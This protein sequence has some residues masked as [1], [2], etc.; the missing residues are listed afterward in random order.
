MESQISALNFLYLTSQDVETRVHLIGPEDAC[1]E[2]KWDSPDCRKQ[3]CNVAPCPLERH[4]SVLVFCPTIG[5]LSCKFKSRNPVL[6]NIELV[7][8]E[9]D[10]PIKGI[11]WCHASFIKLVLGHHKIVEY[12]I[13][14]Q[15]ML[16]SGDWVD[17]S[18]SCCW[19]VEMMESTAGG[20]FPSI[21][22][23]KVWKLPTELHL[24]KY[25]F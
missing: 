9:N 19:C 13:L 20:S 21:D 3:C 1:N 25:L 5:F 6:V 14:Q 8:N 18:W 24:K 12:D 16:F 2:G 15:L 17:F 11:S 22:T 7:T 10:F 4:F 23:Q